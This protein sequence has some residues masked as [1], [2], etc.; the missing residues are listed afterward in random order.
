MCTIPP[1]L[2]SLSRKL[3]WRNF[4]LSFLASL[5]QARVPFFLVPQQLRELLVVRDALARKEEAKEQLRT[6]NES[7]VGFRGFPR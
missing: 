3:R 1:L 2:F 5:R 4:L 6:D 7:R